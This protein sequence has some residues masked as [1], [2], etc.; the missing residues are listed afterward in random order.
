LNAKS[1][2]PISL[3]LVGVTAC[4]GTGIDNDCEAFDI[5]R[6]PASH[7][8]LKESFT[9]LYNN[10]DTLVF[11]NTSWYI[12]KA[13]NGPLVAPCEPNFY[14]QFKSPDEVMRVSYS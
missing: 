8:Y 2:L 10:E 14:T 12:N 9:Y 13:I 6:L 1:I 7:K 3:L 5:K 4:I 11:E